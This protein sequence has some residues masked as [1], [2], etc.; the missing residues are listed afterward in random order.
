MKEVKSILRLLAEVTNVEEVVE[1]YSTAP[2][3][4]KQALES[5]H[6]KT[7]KRIGVIMGFKKGNEAQ[8]VKAIVKMCENM[9]KKTKAE[10]D[11]PTPKRTPKKT[12]REDKVELKIDTE[13]QKAM[14]RIDPANYELL[15]H[16]IAKG[17]QQGSRI[18]V[19][20]EYRILDG[21]N[22]YRAL[23]ELGK[24]VTKDMIEIVELKEDKL[25]WIARKNLIQTRNL[26]ALQRL[27]WFGQHCESFVNAFYEAKYGEKEN[28]KGRLAAEISVSQSSLE[29]YE[30]AMIYTPEFVEGALKNNAD[31]SVRALW[32]EG[33]EALAYLK[34]VDEWTRKMNK[35]DGSTEPTFFYD[36]MVA[37]GRR[38]REKNET[39][40]I[41]HKGKK[42]TLIVLYDDLVTEYG[43]KMRTQDTK[44]LV[45]LK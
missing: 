15:K 37:A 44:E 2:D 31:I 33:E 5:F 35:E 29:R 8:L 40:T 21:H 27:L 28:L 22:R 13:V 43:D 20:K 26:N 18:L 45:A 34:K 30:R 10:R 9:V 16:S 41:K 39:A 14:P 3:A 42:K 23:I 4:F 12:P 11:K 17:W 32:K 1:I 7:L 38:A 6:V 25:L 36:S 24:P 19:D